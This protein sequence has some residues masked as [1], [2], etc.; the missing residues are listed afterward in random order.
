MSIVYVALDNMAANGV[1]QN[2]SVFREL[3]SADQSVTIDM[4]KVQE[5]DGS[6]VGA[7]AHVRRSLKAKGHDV[8]VINLSKRAAEV[9]TDLGLRDVLVPRD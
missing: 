3:A 8:H 5:L 1:K 7:V 2:M 4:S 9:L 6:G